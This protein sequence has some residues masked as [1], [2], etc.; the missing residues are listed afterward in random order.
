MKLKKQHRD[1]L[2]HMSGYLGGVL[3]AERKI[4]GRDKEACK[5]D[6]VYR[7]ILSAIGSINEALEQDALLIN[8]LA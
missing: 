8:L 4:P 1:R 6:T 2:L 3:E 7:A 5:K